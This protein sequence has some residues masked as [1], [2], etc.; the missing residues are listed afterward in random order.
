M[1]YGARTLMGT[2]GL[3]VH[4]HYLP[5][6]GSLD[7]SLQL[8]AGTRLV[9][10]GE[11]VSS[12]RSGDSVEFMENLTTGYWPLIAQL[13]RSSPLALHR[14]DDRAAAARVR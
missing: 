7:F 5:L 2:F 4:R 1:K 10:A 6:Q 12:R 3:E 14:G 8:P 9:L 11:P 13:S